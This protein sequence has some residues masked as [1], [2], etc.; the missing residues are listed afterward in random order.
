MTPIAYVFIF[1]AFCATNA[2][3]QTAPVDIRR[4][5]DVFAEQCAECHSV[6]EGKQ[7]KGP[8]L[9]GISGRKA[10]TQ[11][12]FEYSEALRNA[13]WTWDQERLAF[14]LSQPAKKANPGGKMKFDGVSDKADL[15]NLCGYLATLH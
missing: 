2:W 5:A 12:G 1:A 11:P 14:Y 13:G 9:F 3:A 6:R 4:G 7:K 10:A 8:S 15:A